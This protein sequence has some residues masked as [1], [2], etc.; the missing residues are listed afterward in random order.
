MGFR[1]EKLD[2]YRA[3]IEHV[4]WAYR[5]CRALSAAGNANRKV[6]LYHIVA[7]LTK[8]GQRG[9]AVNEDPAKF[10][11]CC[12]TIVFFRRSFKFN[13]PEVDKHLE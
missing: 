8:L 12:T 3:A 13:K 1:H 6:L 11:V 9:Y 7:M 2:V 5:F 4:G 10:I